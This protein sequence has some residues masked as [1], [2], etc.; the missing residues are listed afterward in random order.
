MDSIV[1]GDPLFDEITEADARR[2]RP[3]AFAGT[4][5]LPRDQI[6]YAVHEEKATSCST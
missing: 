1:R 6:M 3:E 5:R 4:N 2:G